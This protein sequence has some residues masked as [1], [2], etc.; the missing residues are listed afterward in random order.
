MIQTKLIGRNNELDELKI[1][2]SDTINGGGETIFLH[3][4]AGVGKTRLVEELIQIAKSKYFKILNGYCQKESLTP[5]MSMDIALKSVNLDYLIRD[6]PPPRADCIYLVNNAGLM[7]SKAERSESSLDPEIFTSM[8]NAVNAFVSDSFKMM[9]KGDKIYGLS[10]LEYGEWKIIIDHGVYISLV[11]IIKGREN[12]FLKDD[13][14]RIL[15]EVENNYSKVLKDWDGDMTNVEGSEELIKPFITSGKYDGIDYAK[16]NSK[17]KISRLYDNVLIGLIRESKNQPLLLFIDDLQWADPSM[18]GLIHYLARNT[19]TSPVL[20]IGTYRPEDVGVA[21]DGKTHR[22]VETTQLMNREGLLHA[23]DLKR[24]P[25]SSTAE[26]INAMFPNNDF[27]KEFL[28]LIHKETDGNPFFVIELMK[29]LREEKYIDRVNNTWKLMRDLDTITI[30]SKIY[31]VIVRRLN[32]LTTDYRNILDCASMVGEKFGLKSVSHLSQIDKLSLLKHLQTI[33]RMHKLIHSTEGEYKFDHAMI[34]EVLYNSMSPMLKKEYHRMIAEFLEIENRD[35]I[36]IV[37]GD[38]ATHYYLAKKV[39]KALPY[40]MQAAEVAKKQYANEECIRYCA[41]ALELISTNAKYDT[42]RIQALETCGDISSLVGRFNEAIHYF[43]TL[44]KMEVKPEVK[45]WA[46]RKIANI[47]GKTGKYKE[48]LNECSK[49]FDILSRLDIAEKGKVAVEK[50]TILMWMGQDNEAADSCNEAIRLF[51]KCM[52][53]KDDFA[54]VY[55]RLGTIYLDEGE[56]DLALEY[57]NKSLRIREETN[58]VEGVSASCNNMGE[59]YRNL[60]MFDKALDLYEKGLK[61]DIKIGDNRGISVIYS[62][63]G[64]RALDMGEYE[65]SIHFYIKSTEICDRIGNRYGT[66]WNSCGTAEAYLKKGD[67]ENAEYW[68][69]KGRIIANDI[70]SNEVVGWSLKVE[71]MINAKKSHFEIAEQKFKQSITVFEKAGMKGEQ[72]KACYEYGLMLID[73]GDKD[74]AKKWLDTSLELFKKRKM[75]KWI[76]KATEVLK[77]LQ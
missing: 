32:K 60:G 21:W 71:G 25:I 10:G 24:L 38:L 42:Q 77:S 23:I 20:I 39:D 27:P 67:L 12:E 49:A 73:K 62:S 44:S 48:G 30:P 1:C 41:H 36:D 3:G 28:P 35:N 14:D 9:G 56:F 22:L 40:L 50:A 74:K 15:A 76:E 37:I 34:R 54:L 7:I 31:D 2:L 6:K 52:G 19:R 69:I 68:C 58:N 8:L 55:H 47:Y 43:D 5:Y 59:V 4:E 72:G 51:E 17:L 29:L 13:M 16:D 46:H 45:A 63:L 53:A 61:I 33:E 64:D 75:E 26:F 18:L 70:G 65:K 11:A 57:L 66:S